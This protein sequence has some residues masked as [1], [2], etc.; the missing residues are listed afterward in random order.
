MSRRLTF[1]LLSLGLCLASGAGT[2]CNGDS[3][4][5]AAAQTGDGGTPLEDGGTRSDAPIRNV[6]A[7]DPCQVAGYYFDEKSDCDVVRCP[8][9]TCKCPSTAMQQAGDPPPPDEEVTLSACVPNKGCLN[10][11]DCTRICDPALKLTR[12]AC[13]ERLQGA[14]SEA[15]STSADCGGTECRDES[16]GK[17][18]VNDLHCAEDGHCG[19]GFVCRFDPSTLDSKTGF[20]TALGT[21]SDGGKDSVCYADRDCKYGLCNGSRCNGGLEGEPCGMD[22]Q[23]SSGFCR[24]SSPTDTSGSCVSGKQGSSCADEGDCESALHCYQ[25]A[26]QSGAV[27]QLCET[28]DQCDSNICV[29][30]RCRGGE[31]GS[32]CQEDADC[33]SGICAG[34]TCTSGGLLAPCYEPTDCKSG[35]RCARS[36][37]TDGSKGSPCS[38]ATDCSVLACVR[39]ACSDGAN[40]APCDTPSDCTSGRCADPPGVEV[41]TCTSGAKGAPCLFSTD[42]VSNSCSIQGACN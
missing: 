5:P 10:L 26:C 2:A 17:I 12:S 15:C 14:G 8:K 38:A 13:D 21:C 34:Y 18:C 22:S 16:A 31:P 20:P 40:G 24:K 42:C 6:N 29:S 9:L 30:Q 41:G 32:T 37:C 4:A 36:K 39:G 28:D 25:G 35:L 19:G 23:C 11:A 33:T 3:T 1:T 27:G 7:T